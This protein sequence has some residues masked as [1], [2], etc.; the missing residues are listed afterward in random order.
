MTY[1]LVVMGNNSL[2]YFCRMMTAKR[3]HF[4]SKVSVSVCAP[5]T[6]YEEEKKK[7]NNFTVWNSKGLQAFP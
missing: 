6:V 7:L 3:E 1:L 5:V 4:W 2:L